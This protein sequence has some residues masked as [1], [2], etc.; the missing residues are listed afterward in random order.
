MVMFAIRQGDICYFDYGEPRGS[1]PAK[2]RPSV[3]VQNDDLN[4]SDLRTTIV[5]PLSSNTALAAFANNIFLPSGVTLLPKDSVT[6]AHLQT[7]VNK[8]D[9]EYPD[10]HL[11]REILAEVLVGVHAV[12]APA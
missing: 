6:V 9:L 1:L 5:L 8:S 12:T 11:P 3:V 7:V 2:R 10:S 4:L